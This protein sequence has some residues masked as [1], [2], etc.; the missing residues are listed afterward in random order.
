[1]EDTYF[2]SLLRGKGRTDKGK[3]NPE[4]EQT[5]WKTRVDINMSYYMGILLLLALLNI[6][7]SYP[8]RDAEGLFAKTFRSWVELQWVLQ[9]CFGYTQ[10]M[11]IVGLCLEGGKS[12]TGWI[13]R[14]VN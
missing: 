6:V 14:D 4:A 12:V 8:L 9:L 10:L 2:P 13:L 7:Y 1:M 5:C 11:I 3:L